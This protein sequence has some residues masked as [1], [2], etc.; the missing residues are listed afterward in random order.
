MDSLNEINLYFMLRLLKATGTRVEVA[1]VDFSLY[2]KHQYKRTYLGD[3]RDLSRAL[4]GPHF[5]SVVDY[6]HDNNTIPSIAL[7]SSTY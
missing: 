3:M 6:Y 7:I 5:R 1:L 4:Q 2:A